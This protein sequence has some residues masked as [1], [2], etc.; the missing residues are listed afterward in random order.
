MNK[1]WLFGVGLVAAMGCKGMNITDSSAGATEEV[2]VSD[3]SD[4][5]GSK[6]FDSITNETSANVDYQPG[7]P[8]V[9][10]SGSRSDTEQFV[11]KREGSKLIIT[12]KNDAH[13]HGTV[14]V[15]LKS[16]ALKSFDLE[17]SGNCKLNNLKNKSLSVD[18]SGSG[19]ISVNGSCHEAKLVIGGSGSIDFSARDLSLVK[20]EIDGSGSIRVGKASNAVAVVSGSGSVRIESTDKLDASISGSGEIEYGGNPRVNAATAGSGSIHHI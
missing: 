4:A 16:H 6:D 3:S 11:I 17:G 8:S 13:I 7:N 5:R 10:L 18:L 1:I 2:V 12:T 15:H 14:T 20:A 19:E 9:S